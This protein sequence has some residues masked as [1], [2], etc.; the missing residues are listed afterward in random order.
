[1][2]FSGE[3]TS[4]TTMAENVTI[5]IIIAGRSDERDFLHFLFKI[6][7][8]FLISNTLRPTKRLC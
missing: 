5:A 7:F 3:S 2:K 1:M 4:T 8:L 6:L